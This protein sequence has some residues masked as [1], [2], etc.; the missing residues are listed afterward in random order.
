MIEPQDIPEESRCFITGEPIIDSETARFTSEFDA[1]VSE[2]GQDIVE[3]DARAVNPSRENEIIFRE[4]YAQDEADAARWDMALRHLD[5]DNQFNG[6][7]K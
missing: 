4:W 7:N 5:Y 6:D 1:W 2:E 3:E